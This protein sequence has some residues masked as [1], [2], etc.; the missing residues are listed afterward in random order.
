MLTIMLCSQDLLYLIM[1]TRKSNQSAQFIAM[2]KFNDLRL[3][4]FT[5]PRL[6]LL[7]ECF[8]SDYRGKAA[9]LSS[10]GI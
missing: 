8:V 3:K 1:A 7:I 4:F 5:N 6:F 10:G 9:R 2:A